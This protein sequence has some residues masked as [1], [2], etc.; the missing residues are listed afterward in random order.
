MRVYRVLYSEVT[1]VLR[2]RGFSFFLF[3]PFIALVFSLL[4]IAGTW[5][6]RSRNSDQWSNTR[7]I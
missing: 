6:M 5:Y 2:I 3:P 1:A 4:I 7:Y